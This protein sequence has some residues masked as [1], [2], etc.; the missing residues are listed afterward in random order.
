MHERNYI[1]RKILF[2]LEGE[3]CF[4]SFVYTPDKKELRW[5]VYLREEHK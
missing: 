2:F 1:Q 3:F 4:L 5:V